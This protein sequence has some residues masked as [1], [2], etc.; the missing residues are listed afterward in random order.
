MEFVFE[1]QNI[2]GGQD[3][4]ELV[5]TFVE[6]GDIGMAGK[7]KFFAIAKGTAMFGKVMIVHIVS[8]KRY[9]RSRGTARRAP[10]G[11]GS[12]EHRDSPLRL[13]I[14]SFVRSFRP[15]RNPTGH[16]R[17]LPGYQD[18]IPRSDEVVP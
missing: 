14:E 3:Q 4:V 1:T 13:F 17:R 18:C 16:L 10:T 8:R 6:A 15:S 11:P 7:T 5:A 9:L 2:I 12:G